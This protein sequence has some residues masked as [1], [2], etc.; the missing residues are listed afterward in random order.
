MDKQTKELNR[1]NN[2]LDKQVNTENLDAFTNI[3]CYLRGANISEHNQEVIRQDLLEMVLSAQK[4]GE[5]I[6]S[7]VGED[8]KVFCDDIIASLPPK[9]MAEKVLE[10]FD[11]ICWCL[12]ILGAINIIIAD[13]TIALV[14]D[15]ATGRPLNFEISISVGSMISLGLTIVSAFIIVEVILKNPFKAGKKEDVSKTRTFF[16]GAGIMAVFLF[17]AWVGKTP[18]FTVNVFAACIFTLALYIAHRVLAK[19][20]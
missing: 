8:Y 14:C 15:L 3:I 13:E 7:V 20:R 11:I 17:I 12:S 19:I 5:N 10:F 4:R 1:I 16:I 2:E 18:L 9:S 6:K